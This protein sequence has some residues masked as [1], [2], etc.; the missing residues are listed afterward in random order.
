M[1]M[2]AYSYLGENEAWLGWLRKNAVIVSNSWPTMRGLHRFPQNI[3]TPLC[4]PYRRHRQVSI[5]CKTCINALSGSP[6]NVGRK[7]EVPTVQVS[8]KPWAD[9]DPRSASQL[10]GDQAVRSDVGHSQ[11][12]L[13][14]TTAWSAA[15]QCC[16]RCYYCSYQILRLSFMFTMFSSIMVFEYCIRTDSLRF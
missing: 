15:T 2:L 7:R 8:N 4:I 3:A 5:V 13:R 11:P 9:V 12:I 14:S 6:G 10:D 16:Q 1:Y